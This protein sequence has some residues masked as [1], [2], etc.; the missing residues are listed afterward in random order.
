LLAGELGDP[1]PG[2][3]AVATRLADVLVV[4]T[5][6]AWLAD[7]SHEATGWIA[8]LRDPQLGPA[9]AAV[10]RTPGHAWTLASLAAHAAMSRSAF[11]ARFTAV[12]GT[13]A[14]TYVAEAR[15]RAA[16]ARLVGGETVAAVAHALGYG[17][18]AAFS[19]AF[20]RITGETPGRLRRATAA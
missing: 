1:R 18:E 4:E 3:G 19:R 2:G 16:R 17:S 20:S 13:P 14:M 10:H 12:V 8:A 15:M 11:A 5:V 6:R 7:Q 9:I